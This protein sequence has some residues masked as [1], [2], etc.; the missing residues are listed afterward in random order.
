MGREKKMETERREREREK[1]T[2][3]GAL[4]YSGLGHQD[5]CLAEIGHSG[6]QD[7]CPRTHQDTKTPGQVS[8]DRCPLPKIFPGHLQDRCPEPPQSVAISS[9][10]NYTVEH[11]ERTFL[12]NMI[13][14]AT[15]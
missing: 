11:V 6:H 12:R 9:A 8:Q 10:H 15:M 3:T 7:R 2:G 4:G 1:D 14:I 13:E 5:R